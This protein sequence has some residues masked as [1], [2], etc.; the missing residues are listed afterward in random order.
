MRWVTLKVLLQGNDRGCV[1]FKAPCIIHT[2]VHEPGGKRI[3]DYYWPRVWVGVCELS[4]SSRGYFYQRW[5]Y[6][7]HYDSGLARILLCGAS[8]GYSSC[9]SNFRVQENFDKR[10]N[11]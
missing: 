10:D 8:I 9:V 2:S 1:E 3:G 11:L 5:G 6:Y 7:H 4:T